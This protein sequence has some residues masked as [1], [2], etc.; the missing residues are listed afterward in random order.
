MTWKKN[1]KVPQFELPCADRIE[2]AVRAYNNEKVKGKL[3][4]RKAADR[5]GVHWE[6]LR[7]RVNRGQISR[8]E[9]AQSRQILS[10]LEEQVLVTWCLQLE[11]WGWPARIVQLRRMAIE[12]LRAKGYH[13]PLGPNWQGAFFRRH[14]EIKSMF[15][16]PRDKKRFLATDYEILKHFFELF[17]VTKE[18]YK[19]HDDDIY[20]MDEKGAAIGKIGSVRC[21]VSKHAKKP[22]IAQ[23]G[24]REWATVIECVN[25]TGRVLSFWGIF[26]GVLQQKKWAHTMEEI[27]VKKW[28]IC[29]SENGWT[30]NELGSRWLTDCF[31]PETRETKGEYRMLLFDGHSSHITTDAIKFCIDHNIIPLCLPPHTTHLLQP[32]DVGLF[33]PVSQLYQNEIEE[34]TRIRPDDYVD[35]CDFLEVYNT[36]RPKAISPHNIESAWH[37][38]GLSPFNPEV[39]LS[40]LEP[41]KTFLDKIT[42]PN[43]R[44]PTAIITAK[45]PG[46][47]AEIE[48]IL[49]H[50]KGG[51]IEAT[52]ALTKISKTAS[53]ALADVVIAKATNEQFVE[54]EKLK[55]RKKERDGGDYGKARIMSEEVL[56]QRRLNKI[57]KE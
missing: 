10:Q 29:T 15:T 18:K 6:N 33:G 41:P 34:R 55:A 19:I 54:G 13:K 57:E 23:D 42:P 24:N 1:R 4:L 43:S 35:K 44:P 21:I 32:L 37:E 56:E 36:I 50:V 28:K 39:V 47:I 51:D 52:E 20:N 12:L 40:K 30:D 49:K 17:R 9:F 11:A 2:L 48:S 45:T 53:L 27:G 5:Q 46:N 22:Y 31:E 8:V 3:S 16:R 25:V 7:N 26:K 38:C 14:P